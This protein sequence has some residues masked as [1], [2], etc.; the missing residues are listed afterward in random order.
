MLEHATVKNP[1]Y[2]IG[3]EW[4]VMNGLKQVDDT[5]FDMMGHVLSL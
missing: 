4:A 3:D 5:T 1:Y 2:Q